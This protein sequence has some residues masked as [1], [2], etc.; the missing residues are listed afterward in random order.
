MIR[1][2]TCFLLTA[3]LFA[4]GALYAENTDNI[5][6]RWGIAPIAAPYYTP[7][8]G[9]AIGAYLVTTL[10]PDEAS[11]FTTPDELSLYIAYTQKKQATLGL[12]P[13][14]FLGNGAVKLSG[15]GELN[16][17]PT[18]FWGIGPD[19][20]KD[21]REIYTPVESWGDILLLVRA[22]GAL[23]IGPLVHFRFSDIDDIED[24]G[25]IDSGEIRGGDGTREIGTGISFQYDT[26]DNLFYP[27]SGWFIE[28]RSS[29]NR[30]ELNSEYSF[31][32]FELDARWFAG[33]YGEHVIAMQVEAKAAAGDIPLQSYCGIGGNEIM[34]GYLKDRYLDRTSLAAQAEYRFPLI[35][36]IAGV[37]FG[38][39]GEVQDNPG[40]Y[41][42]D[43][44]HY[45]GGGG[46]R[47]ILDRA[48]HI[49]ARVDCGVNDDGTPNFYFLVKEAF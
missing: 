17:Y 5:K 29:F 42:T 33:I 41:N 11:S 21:D 32:R 37:I 28:G 20:D 22:Y 39:A 26:R 2:I 30:E 44:I 4:E 40:D 6:Q 10:K 23:Y 19:T 38:A 36:R 47:L 13:N 48:Q 46:L 45:S 12:I 15:K 1:C 31:T 8:T 18:A 35:W 7:D 3:L 27:V 16:K 25:I 34:R 14:I 9:W 24:D 49:A 43:D